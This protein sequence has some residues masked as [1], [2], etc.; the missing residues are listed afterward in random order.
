MPQKNGACCCCIKP[1]KNGACCCRKNCLQKLAC[2]KEANKDAKKRQ[3]V[4][5]NIEP[6]Y[7]RTLRNPMENDSNGN[8]ALIRAIRCCAT[9][10]HKQHRDTAWSRGSGGRLVKFHPPPSPPCC[11]LRTDKFR[12]ATEW[13]WFSSIFNG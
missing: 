8:A 13:H 11:L 2:R 1:Q 12:Q 4:N 9:K 3:R 7:C 10:T 6:K 5:H